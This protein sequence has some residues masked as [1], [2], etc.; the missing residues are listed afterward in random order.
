MTTDAVVRQW[1][2]EVWNEGKEST[3]DRLLAAD[4]KVY[5]LGAPGDP[6]MVGAAAFKPVFHA[7]RNAIGNMRIDVERTIVDGEWCAAFCRVKGKH[8]G[9]A[10]GGAPTNRTVEFTGTVL[11]R[12]RDGKLVEGWNVFDFLLMYQQI[13]WVKNPVTP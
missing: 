12:V 4:A 8:V 7:F 10:L 9:D 6:P 5:G 1:F 3:I 11:V 13:G 2:K